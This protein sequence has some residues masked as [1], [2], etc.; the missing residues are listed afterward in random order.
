MVGHLWNVKRWSLWQNHCHRTVGTWAW[1]PGHFV[2]KDINWNIWFFQWFNF[3]TYIVRKCG[4]NRS[5]D[6]LLYVASN[7]PNR[8]PLP[9]YAVRDIGL[10]IVKYCSPSN[11]FD[12]VSKYRQ[13]LFLS[14]APPSA[15]PFISVFCWPVHCARHQLFPVPCMYTI[16]QFKYKY[17]GCV[18]LLEEELGY[19]HSIHP[20]RSLGTSSIRWISFSLSL[21]LNG[22]DMSYLRT[23]HFSLLL[24]RGWVI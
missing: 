1:N 4:S 3:C 16:T 21:L 6:P 20:L 11:L 17:R 23:L 9:E 15:H 24:N 22:E 7:I 5:N 2:N 19:I 18:S 8:R 13:I 14:A 10:N 12:I